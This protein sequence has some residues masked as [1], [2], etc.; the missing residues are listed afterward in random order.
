MSSSF[1]SSTPFT[2]AIGSH[3]PCALGPAKRTEHQNHP[4]DLQDYHREVL[5]VVLVVRVV[6]GVVLVVVGVVVVMKNKVLKYGLVCSKLGAPYCLRWNLLA[7]AAM[8]FPTP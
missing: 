8:S 2:H 3:L 5:V 4:R 6:L 7:P 1:C